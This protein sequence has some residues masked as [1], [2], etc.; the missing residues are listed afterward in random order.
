[1]NMDFLPECAC[2]SKYAIILC[3]SVFYKFFTSSRMQ[4]GSGINF[5]CGVAKSLLISLPI[6]E[7]RVFPIVTPSALIIGITLNIVYFLRAI[8][9]LSLLKMNFK[10]PWTTQD[11]FVSPGWTLPVMTTI[12][13][14]ASSSLVCPKS[15]IVSIGTSIPP[16]LVVIY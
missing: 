1:M 13:F 11:A 4:Y 14:L 6:N 9:I 5:W 12:F 15:V 2:T 16:R 8:A 3:L 7:H 10:I